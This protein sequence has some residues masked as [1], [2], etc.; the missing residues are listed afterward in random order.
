VRSLG[1]S[2]LQGGEV[3]LMVFSLAAWLSSSSPSMELHSRIRTRRKPTFKT[4]RR[5]GMGG[6]ILTSRWAVGKFT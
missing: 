3:Q 5:N 2:A 6:T 4:L 1:I